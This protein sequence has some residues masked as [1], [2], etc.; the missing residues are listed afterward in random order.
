[1]HL[2]ITKCKYNHLVIN[3]HEYIYYLIVFLWIPTLL[4]KKKI[5]KDA[6]A[7]NSLS[8]IVWSCS[9]PV[10]K[11][12]KS[13]FPLKGFEFQVFTLNILYNPSLDSLLLFLRKRLNRN[14]YVIRIMPLSLPLLDYLSTSGHVLSTTTLLVDNGLYLYCSKG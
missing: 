3:Y 2:L 6:A 11:Y 5:R 12:Y 4:C 14:F 13:M 8:K 10:Y 9:N 1:M 7:K